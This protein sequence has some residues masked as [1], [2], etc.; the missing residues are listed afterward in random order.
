MYQKL[1]IMAM[2]KYHVGFYLQK[3]Y[4]KNSSESQIRMRVRWDG[5]LLQLNSGFTISPDK[6]A[7]GEV[8]RGACNKDGYTRKEIN[9]HLESMSE[10]VDAIFARIRAEHGR[11]PSLE[12][13][14]AMFNPKAQE[15]TD[16]ITDYFREFYADNSTRW[17]KATYYKFN[18][19]QTHLLDFDKKLNVNDFD[20]QTIDRFRDYLLSRGLQNTVINK[21]WKILKWFLNWCDSKGYVTSKGWK[22]YKMNLKTIP[23]QIIYLE[24][25][26]LMNLYNFSFPPNKKYLEDARDFFCFECF[27]GLRYSDVRHLEWSCVK[28][29]YISVDTL[30]DSDHVNIPLNKYSSAILQKHI[31]LPQPF[32]PISS[33]KLNEYIKEACMIAGIVQPI[34]KAHYKGAERIEETLCKYQLVSSHTGRR[35]FICNALIMGIPESTVMLMTGHSDFKAMQPYISASNIALK[36]AMECFNRKV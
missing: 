33:Q 11:F 24:W 3:T 6:W 35:T 7:N 32:R 5:H 19:I 12:E 31:G 36:E 1:K 16:S 8:K 30:K 4:S 22:D 14:R 17:G 23:H 26:E 27:T 20:A 9:E 2:K 25:G 29:D 10:R 15:R 28:N 18:T 21:E 34:R 13:L